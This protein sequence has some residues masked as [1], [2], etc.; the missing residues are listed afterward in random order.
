M[1]K[2]EIKIKASSYDSPCLSVIE[3][4]SERCFLENSGSQGGV[5]TDL[6]QIGNDPETMPSSRFKLF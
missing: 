1:K 6:D 3:L 5:N 2:P 4:E